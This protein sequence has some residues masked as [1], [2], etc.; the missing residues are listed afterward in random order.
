M[1]NLYDDPFLSFLGGYF[2]CFFLRLFS[3]A[4]Q[5]EIF[6]KRKKINVSKKEMNKKLESSTQFQNFEIRR[7]ATKPN[8][9]MTKE[10]AGRALAD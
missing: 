9:K 5:M 3:F 7:E 1:R 10:S 2:P 4:V 8:S 6:A